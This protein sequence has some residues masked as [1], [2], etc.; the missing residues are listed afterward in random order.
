[1][2]GRAVVV[3]AGDPRIHIFRD[4]LPVLLERLDH[5]R[6][7]HRRGVALDKGF[8]EEALVHSVDDHLERR[9]VGPVRAEMGD[10][11]E[12]RRDRLVAVGVEFRPGLRQALD[13]RL[14]HR[15]GRAPEPV[16]AVD[17]HGRRDPVA[18][19]LHHGQE[20]R[21]DD[22]VPSLLVRHRV[23]IGDLA[24]F[25]PL[26]DL[27]ALELH[28]GRRV[29]GDDVGA[30]LRQRVGGMAGD[31]GLLPF[32]ASGGEHLAKLGDRR[33]VGAFGPLAEQVRLGFGKRDGR[34]G[35]VD[36]SSSKR[37]LDRDHRFSPTCEPT[38]VGVGSSDFVRIS[39]I[40]AR[41]PRGCLVDNE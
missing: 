8:L 12:M 26:G 27:G 17:I 28:R 18:A 37:R 39:A 33:R 23:E 34:R 32:A 40:C 24:G 3:A 22:L 10:A 19:R 29:A 4:H 36:E 38:A 20:I 25:V 31:R 6:R 16:D 30:Q 1:M 35:R 5:F 7:A 2:A 15:L 14:L 11:D 41:S 21:R 9:G 13:P